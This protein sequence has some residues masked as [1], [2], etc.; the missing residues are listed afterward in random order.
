MK[1]IKNFLRK[2]DLFGAPFN[3][4]YKKHE[5]YSSSL[6]GLI[7][8]LFTILTLTFGIYYLIPFLNRKNLSIIY[9][10]MNLPKTEQIKLQDSKAV[11]AIGLDCDSNG[12]FKADDVFNLESRYVIYT[13]NTEGGYDKDKQ[14][15]PSHYCKY[16]D[17]YNKYNT[18]FDYLRLKGYQCLNNYSQTLEGIYSGQVFSY[19]EFSVNAKNTSKVA[20]DSVDEYLMENDC[21]LQI[22][23]TDITIELSN[24]KEPIKP[25]LNSFFIQLNPI[26]F[27]KRNVYFMNQY[28]YDDD[29]LLTIFNEEQKPKE[30]ETLFS[31]Y[32]EYSLYLGLDRESTRPKNFIN[33]AKIYVRA[34]IKK[35]RYKKNLSKIN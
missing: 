30:M 3:F 13:K 26:L 35:N 9:Y 32:E 8:V 31:R 1:K 18:S 28:L 33:Y 34:D 22:V 19:Y 21:K 24:Y 11:F 12:R 2:I 29:Q 5:K 23:Y 17:F 4:K 25:F 14:L 6:G 27:I 20:F 15:L 10:T 16:K 7:I